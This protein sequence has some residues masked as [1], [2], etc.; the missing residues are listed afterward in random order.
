VGESESGRYDFKKIGWDFDGI[1]FGKGMTGGIWCLDCDAM[2][3][4]GGEMGGDGSSGW[5]QGIDQARFKSVRQ[6]G[7]SGTKGMRKG[8]IGQ[9][10]SM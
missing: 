9:S 1:S 10:L 6:E 7:F 2:T 4:R 5:A 3:R 8:G